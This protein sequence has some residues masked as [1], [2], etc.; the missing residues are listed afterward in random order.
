M[1]LNK[2][3][4]NWY[5]GY[6]FIQLNLLLILHIGDFWSLKRIFS[7][8][9]SNISFLNYFFLW[10]IM[11]FIIISYILYI[12]F[13]EDFR[14]EGISNIFNIAILNWYKNWPIEITN[15][16]WLYNQKSFSNYKPFLIFFIIFYFVFYVHTYTYIETSFYLSAF[17][18]YYVFLYITFIHIF[19]LLCN[20]PIWYF[21]IHLFF[22]T[23]PILNH[24]TFRLI[25]KTDAKS[26]P[27]FLA[28]FLVQFI[29][30]EPENSPDDITQG[31]KTFFLVRYPSYFA[32]MVHNWPC[33]NIHLDHIFWL[34]TPFSFF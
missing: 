30:S 19:R 16:T 7:F 23:H 26:Y 10:S 3:E 12:L 28:D 11:Y 31:Y 15:Y 29:I 14:L 8:L 2:R 21:F 6:T 9:C 17:F 5:I 13:H 24:F 27:D 25:Y 22:F 18:Y 4:D 20:M 34:F 33:L 1:I 32:N